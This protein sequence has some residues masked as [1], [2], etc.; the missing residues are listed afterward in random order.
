MSQAFTKGLFSD[1]ERSYGNEIKFYPKELI[2]MSIDQTLEMIRL[3]GD[4]GA[5]FE[6]EKR[7][8]LG[9]KPLK[10]LE[11]VRKMSLNY[12][13]VNIANKYQ[14]G[15]DEDVNTGQTEE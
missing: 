7:A 2:F 12:V 1:N 15:G 4:S 9:L 5:L 8:A 3:L 10:E 13:D 6:N 14:T 11:G